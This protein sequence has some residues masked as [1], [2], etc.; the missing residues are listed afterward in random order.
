MNLF[1]GRQIQPDLVHDMLA[2]HIFIYLIIFSKFTSEQTFAFMPASNVKCV[3]LK[4]TSHIA[5]NTKR[6]IIEYFI[7]YLHNF[8]TEL[9][10]L[11]IN[12]HI[13]MRD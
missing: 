2:H 10:C 12:E 11:H 3:V 1:A 5:I 9:F 6:A 7:V 4:T 13:S 8:I